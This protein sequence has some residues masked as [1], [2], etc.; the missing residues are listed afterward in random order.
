MNCD[1]NAPSRPVTNIR[2]DKRVRQAHRV[3]VDEGEQ[4]EQVE[5][6]A[7]LPAPRTTRRNARPAASH[8]SPHSSSTAGYLGE[9]GACSRGTSRRA[10][11]H[12][13]TGMLS[14]HLMGV[15]HLGQCEGG[16]ESDSP[17]GSRQITTLPNDPKMSPNRNRVVSQSHCGRAS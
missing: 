5:E 4:H 3:P 12:D 7:R 10:S 14:Y 16:L 17:R 1:T 8:S 15:S 6:A 9:M 13:T 11:S 2:T